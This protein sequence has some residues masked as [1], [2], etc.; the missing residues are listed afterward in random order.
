MMSADEYPTKARGMDAK[1][2]TC[3]EP[4]VAALVARVKPRAV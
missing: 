1:A 4:K 2:S 3:L